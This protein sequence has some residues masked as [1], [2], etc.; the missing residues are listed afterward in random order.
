MTTKREADLQDELAAL[1]HQ[2]D[3][4]AVAWREAFG[5]VV[6]R[7]R[8]KPDIETVQRFWAMMNG[9]AGVGP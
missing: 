3:E 9:A 5:L 7:N 1:R 2:R 6:C 4:L 8:S